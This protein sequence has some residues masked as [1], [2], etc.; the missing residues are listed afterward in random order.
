MHR[1]T[2]RKN[3][4]CGKN[5][6]NMTTSDQFFSDNFK[7]VYTGLQKN[8]QTARMADSLF[9]PDDIPILNFMPSNK[10]SNNT[11]NTN[12][13]VKKKI[14]TNSKNDCGNKS[15]CINSDI[16]RD[17]FSFFEND[18]IPSN[19]NTQI[20]SIKSNNEKI[21]NEYVKNSVKIQN[22]KMDNIIKNNEKCGIKT[23]L[24]TRSKMTY[25]FEKK[26]VDVQSEKN[27]ANN[28][29]KLNNNIAQTEQKIQ[30]MIEEELFANDDNFIVSEIRTKTSVIDVPNRKIENHFSNISSP[31]NLPME[32]NTTISSSP[33]KTNVSTC[34]EIGD[35]NEI[36]NKI[37]VAIENNEL[38]CIKTDIE[39]VDESNNESNIK[40]DNE[41]SNESNIKTVN[42]SSNGSDIKTVNE[43]DNESNIKTVNESSNESDIKI[44]NDSNEI[45]NSSNVEIKMGLVNEIVETNHDI[46]MDNSIT[47][48]VQ[49][50]IKINSLSTELSSRKTYMFDEMLQTQNNDGKDNNVILKNFPILNPIINDNYLAHKENLS[51]IENRMTSKEIVKKIDIKNDNINIV[52]MSNIQEMNTS[53]PDN[54]VVSITEK[55]VPVSSSNNSLATAEQNIPTNKLS[56]SKHDWPE[57]SLDNVNTTFKVIGDLNNGSKLKII[58]KKYMAEEDAYVPSFRRTTTRTDILSFLEHLYH[59]TIR[60]TDMLL[61][62]IRSGIN[63]DNKVP[64][65]ENMISNMIIFLHKFDT[66]R[67]VYIKDTSAYAQFDNIK[68]HFIKFRQSLFRDLAIPK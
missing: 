63:V 27:K 39:T 46:K 23:L 55:T 3:E 34:H 21:K 12:N 52:N 9:S 1:R 29:D 24:S 25:P 61:F 32:E 38:I 54:T 20:N 64:E 57:L 44:V 59:E 43:N 26:S 16:R 47:L 7:N 40:T 11:N 36:N 2:N 68:A 50:S 49:N 45:S 58:D 19:Y 14:S 35:N 4:L 42:E 22:E 13:L 33:I 30:K 28:N 48:P 62:D 65:L 51:D 15:K 5:T 53:V 8:F 31:I 41:S 10:N 18:P 17:H 60:N 37:N 67:N 56:G 66:M 6:D